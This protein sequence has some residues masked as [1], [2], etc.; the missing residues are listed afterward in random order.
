[1]C[2]YSASQRERKPAIREGPSFQAVVPPPAGAPDQ[3]PRP[4]PAGRE[5]DDPR[6]GI[7][8]P[9]ALEA[10]ALAAGPEKD[11]ADSLPLDARADPALT[12]NGARI[13]PACMKKTF[14]TSQLNACTCRVTEKWDPHAQWCARAAGPRM[15]DI[16][17][18]VTNTACT[19]GLSKKGSSR[20]AVRAR[21]ASPCMQPHQLH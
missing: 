3:A 5:E 19:C 8:G 16:A 1:V 15:H 6:A 18:T 14:A 7:R 12:P 2:F 17:C 20:P 21:A 10:L 11:S 13:S 9:S 4:R